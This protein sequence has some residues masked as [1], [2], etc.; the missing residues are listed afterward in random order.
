[1]IH[2]AENYYGI[3]DYARLCG[4]SAR[5]IRDRI[6]AGSIPF[7]KVGKYYAID[8]K[9]TPPQ[10]RL[11]PHWRNIKT[12]SFSHIPFPTKDLREVGSFSKGRHYSE[13]VVYKAILLNKLDGYVLGDHVFV[14]KDA[15]DAIY[16][17]L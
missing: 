11:N 13:G 1:M 9:G 17:T 5:N 10:N 15:A 2:V 3:E 16:K 14:N 4:V 8:A 6:R 7:L 12:P